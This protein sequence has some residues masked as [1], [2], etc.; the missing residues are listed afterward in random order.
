ME[1]KGLFHFRNMYITSSKKESR[2]PHSKGKRKN[3]SKILL[4]Q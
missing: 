3:L 4:I 2:L 1:V